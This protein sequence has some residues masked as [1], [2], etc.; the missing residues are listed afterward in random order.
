VADRDDDSRSDMGLRLMTLRM[1]HFYGPKTCTLREYL[2]W[3][4]AFEGF[5]LGHELAPEGVPT[6]ADGETLQ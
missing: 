4:K 1:A 6:N 5:I 2:T 3:A